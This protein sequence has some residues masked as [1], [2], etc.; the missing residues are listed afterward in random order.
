MYLQ[1]F[2]FFQ[3]KSHTE[4]SGDQP[5]VHTGKG[6]INI[7]QYITKGSE[8][9][10]YVESLETNAKLLQERFDIASSVLDSFFEKLGNEK[11]PLSEWPQRLNEFAQSYIELLEQIKQL[12]SSDP[13]VRKYRDNALK[14]IETGDFKN[15]E[16][17]LNKAYLVDKGAIE[18]LS[19]NLDER[20][21][22]AAESLHSQALLL[23]TQR[24][25][26]DSIE[27]FKIAIDILPEHRIDYRAAYL[28]D[29]GGRYLIIE[30]MNNAISAL[31]E[32]VQLNRQ[33]N[34]A[35]G[36]SMR[37][38]F[39]LATS[40][41]SLGNAYRLIGELDSCK[42]LLE[43]AYSR[44][45]NLDISNNNKDSVGAACLNLGLLYLQQGDRC[46][47]KELW[48]EAEKYYS[49]SCDKGMAKCIQV[50]FLEDEDYIELLRDGLMQVDQFRLKLK[51]EREKEESA[52]KQQDITNK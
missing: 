11:V 46:R 51:M 43:E 16:I 34:D 17:F 37:S 9:D 50:N 21:V 41:A 20:K 1:L 39:N 24:K 8:D 32:S 10:K 14:A 6:D 30:D 47:A 3:A 23:S 52:R 7:H 13:E 2:A 38:C 15:A 48:V 36:K 27:L 35:S 40:L 22:S 44:Y 26:D 28:N 18:K 31:I 33:V 42:P 49:E 5:I 25:Y 12:S 45:L 4:I 19:E 29:L